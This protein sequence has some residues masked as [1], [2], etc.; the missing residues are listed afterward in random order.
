VLRLRHGAARRGCRASE[1][2]S[3]ATRP[4]LNGGGAC[5]S[6]LRSWFNVRFRSDSRSIPPALPFKRANWGKAEKMRWGFHLYA[7][8]V[9]A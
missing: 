2:V 6:G 4:A 3:G 5:G 9:F 1:A 8:V 7:L